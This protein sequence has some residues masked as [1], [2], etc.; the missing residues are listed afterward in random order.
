MDKVYVIRGSL[1][2]FTLGW[3]ALLPG[4][5]VI[6]GVIAIVISRRVRR[7]TGEEWNPARRHLYCGWLLAWCGLLLSALLLGGMLA[8]AISRI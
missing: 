1:R 5:G 4:L 2:C 6:P 8:V 3:F 7:E